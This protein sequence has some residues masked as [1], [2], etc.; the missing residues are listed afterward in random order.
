MQVHAYKHARLMD[1]SEARVEMAVGFE[2][3]ADRL[4]ANRILASPDAYRRWEAEH[5]HLLRAIS[6][7]A[8]LS[9]QIV[10]LRSAACTL[11][12][13]KALFEYLRDCQVR[14]SRRHRLFALFYGFRDYTNAVLAEHGKYVRCSSSYLCMNY[15]GEHLMRDAALDEPLQ[16]Y[17]QWYGE[18]FRI[19]CD[20]AL[21]ETEEEKHTVAPMEALKPLLKCRLA[22]AHQA[23]LQMPHVPA[24]EW[25]E[26]TIR[27]PTGDTQRLRAL[28]GGT[29]PSPVARL[30]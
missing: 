17:E 26:V 1:E 2:S 8:R 29:S 19:F 12:H 25:R 21:A 18:Y 24:E 16:I 13:R 14:G 9:R 27:K 23:I 5:D 4:V 22:E 20:V 11:V 7:Q 3:E 15:L 6:E 10:M 28:F 30:G